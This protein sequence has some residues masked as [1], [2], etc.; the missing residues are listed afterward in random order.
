MI[1]AFFIVLLQ[2]FVPETY[3]HNAIVSCNITQYKPINEIT[4]FFLE[5]IYEPNDVQLLNNPAL[6]EQTDKDFDRL[7]AV[8]GVLNES[9]SVTPSSSNLIMIR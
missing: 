9:R 6:T 3:D 8:G 5:M 4:P 2:P 7:R 1:H